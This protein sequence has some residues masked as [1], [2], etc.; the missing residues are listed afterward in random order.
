M[1]KRDSVSLMATFDYETY[2]W[3]VTILD[4]DGRLVHWCR[5]MG[6]AGRTT[7]QAVLLAMRS[8]RDGCKNGVR[9]YG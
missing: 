1:A 9:L 4:E 5:V 3:R 6:W 8:W 2:E 7:E